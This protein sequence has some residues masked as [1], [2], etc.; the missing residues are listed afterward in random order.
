MGQNPALRDGD[1][2]RF[3]V[4]VVATSSVRQLLFQLELLVSPV[5]LISVYPVGVSASD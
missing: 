5:F 4:K 3:W 1:G 2:W